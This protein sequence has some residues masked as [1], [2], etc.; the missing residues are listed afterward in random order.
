MYQKRKAFENI[1]ILGLD[2]ISI[3]VSLA[4]AFCIRYGMIFGRAQEGDQGWLFLFMLVL[5]AA[6]N[7][8]VDFNDKFFRRGFLEEFESVVKA[9][10]ILGLSMISIL[11]LL[12]R[13]ADL[14]RLVFS[15]FIILNTVIMLAL[16]L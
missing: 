11:F 12:H 5:Y 15:Y 16:S 3:A 6:I 7:I 13:S 1:L 14:S 4:I 8:F 2:V 10:L 9:E